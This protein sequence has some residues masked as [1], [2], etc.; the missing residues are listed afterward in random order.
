MNRPELGPPTWEEELRGVADRTRDPVHGA[1]RRGVRRR[2]LLRAVMATSI[3]AVVG[4]TVTRWPAPAEPVPVATIVESFGEIASR[5]GDLPDDDDLTPGGLLRTGRESG[6]RLRLT[7]GT[8]LRLDS[9]STLE[10]LEGPARGDLDRPS[11]RLSSGALFFRSPPSDGRPL[12]ITTPFADLVNRGTEYELRLDAG[13]GMELFVSEGAV[14]VRPL[15]GDQLVVQAGERVLVRRDGVRRK[16]DAEPTTDPW[17]V[18][19]SRPFAV[20]GRT[21]EDFVRWVAEERGFE[22]RWL[23]DEQARST[24]LRGGLI[25]RDPEAALAPTLR[26]AG[27]EA[28]I[29]PPRLLVVAP[30]DV[31]SR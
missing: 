1:W 21:L 29:E 5:A 25:W 26:M 30:A 2:R 11:V 23:V 31:R 8:D 15:S 12:A 6:L 22:V 27:L 20:D 13:I 16:P 24:R 19:L 10:W 4:V 17:T 18:R 9:E 14:R 28:R 3:A 7:D